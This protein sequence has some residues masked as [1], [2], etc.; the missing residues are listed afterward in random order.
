MSLSIRPVS[1]GFGAEIL[2]V[3]LAQPM[4]D[5]LFGE[6]R[7]AWRDADGLLL[8]R[9]QDISPEQH[10]AF[11]RRFGELHAGGGN[12]ALARYH[13]PGHPEIYRVS[14]KKQDG[15]PQGRED[16]GTY[17]HSDGSWQPSP[18]MASLLH[19]LEIPPVGGDTIFA[20]MVRAYETLSPPMQRM[21]EGL[22]A[23]HS[24]ASAVLKTSY[25]KEYEGNFEEAAAKKATHPVIRTHPESGR[26][27]LFVNRGFTSH[28]V[29]LSARESDAIL[30]L[31][32]EHSTQPENVYRHSWQRHD[33]VVWDNRCTMHYAVADYKSHGDRYM[34]R[35]TVQGDKPFQ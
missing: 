17:W 18:P 11:S 30:E 26:K 33:L 32:F 2:G 15:V 22:Q 19:A 3:N 14:N 20:N 27:A 29:G 12:S 23:V 1:P 7:Q 28:I 25:A 16:A 9:G 8:I 4:G 21:L 10:I 35:T 13:L 5:N 6:I 24:L 34:Q 31:L